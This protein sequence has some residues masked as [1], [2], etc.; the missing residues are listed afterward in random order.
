MTNM[1]KEKTRVNS[2][3]LACAL[4]AG[5]TAAAQAPPTGHEDHKQHAEHV[6]QQEPSLADQI[7]ELRAKVA[8]LETALLQN[9]QG[10]SQQPAGQGPA[11]GGMQATGGMGTAAPSGSMG[12]GG[13]ASSGMGGMGSSGMGMGGMGMGKTGGGMGMDGMGMGGMR[14]RMGM[15]GM[16]MSASGSMAPSQATDSSS[17]SMGPMPGMGQSQ[18][19][20]MRMMGSMGQASASRT[21][22]LSVLPGFPGASH[23]Y[24][25]GANTHFLDYAEA[26]GLSHE[27]HRQ[28][29]ELHA[30]SELQQNDMQRSLDKLEQDLWVLTS[31]GQ[32]DGDAISRKIREI[33]TQTAEMRLQFIRSVGEAAS[34]LTDAQRRQLVGDYATDTDA[35]SGK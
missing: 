12:M 24:H 31:A 20:Q 27:Q 22:V 10:Q 18:S 16:N 4:I 29:S 28:L 8:K 21:A 13:M 15:S 5:A 9:H 3:A 17:M 11:A 1:R 6:G 35:Q 34:V 23:I 33:A 30:Q 32:P 14:M 19:R 2:L 25:I 26:L 7:A